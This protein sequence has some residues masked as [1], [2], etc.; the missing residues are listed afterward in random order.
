MNS[1]KIAKKLTT[2]QTHDSIELQ[3][4]HTTQYIIERLFS[5]LWK[6]NTYTN[7]IRLEKKLHKLRR[8]R[9]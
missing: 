2:S 6:K 5:K 9:M 3:K 4:T 7:R 8:P 1:N